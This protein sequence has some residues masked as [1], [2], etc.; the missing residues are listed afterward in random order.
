MGRSL[1]KLWGIT[2]AAHVAGDLLQP[3]HWHHRVFSSALPLASCSPMAGRKMPRCSIRLYIYRNA[4]R[5]FDM[6][7]A[8]ALAWVS[9]LYHSCAYVAGREV[10]I[11]GRVYYEEPR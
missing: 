5:Y 7:Y 3:D 1:D 9:V 10:I 8:A 6:G 4:F 2:S 11:G